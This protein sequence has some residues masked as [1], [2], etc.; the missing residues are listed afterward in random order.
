MPNRKTFD[1]HEKMDHSSHPPQHRQPSDLK[2]DI[3]D[4]E[5]LMVT[6]PGIGEPSGRQISK[7]RPGPQYERMPEC[8]DRAVQSEVTT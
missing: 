6:P 8:L 2:A 4:P 5:D 7:Q 3:Q 1:D